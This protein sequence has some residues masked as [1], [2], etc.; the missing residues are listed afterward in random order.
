MVRLAAGQ[1]V[2]VARDGRFASMAFGRGALDC[3]DLYVAVPSGA[4]RRL[5]TDTPGYYPA[6]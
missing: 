5:A 3:N 6:Q 1:R 2:E 4:M